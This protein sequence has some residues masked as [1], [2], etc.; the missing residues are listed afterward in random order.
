MSPVPQPRV[1]AFGGLDRVAKDYRRREQHR[2][3]NQRGDHDRRNRVVEAADESD[4]ERDEGNSPAQISNTI[5]ELRVLRNA[6][7]SG[8]NGIG[9][10]RL[11]GSNRLT[12]SKKK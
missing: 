7:A 4:D 5:G 2:P 1:F 11:G 3:D 8:A 9:H 6:L 12:F 10:H